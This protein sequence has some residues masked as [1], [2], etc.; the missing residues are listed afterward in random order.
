MKC[1]VFKKPD[2]RV[3]YSWPSPKYQGGHFVKDRS[4]PIVVEVDDKEKPIIKETK[5]LLKK[6]RKIVGYVKKKVIVDYKKKELTIDCCK[7]PPETDGLPYIDLDESD[8]PSEEGRDWHG[9]GPLHIEGELR[10]E[11]LKFDEKWEKFLMPG[12]VI[13]SKEE[14]NIERYLDALLEQKSPDPIE[15]IR[16]FRKLQKV[17]KMHYKRDYR[18]LCEIAMDGLDRAEIE[19]PTIRQK[20][21]DKIK[22]LKK[23][24]A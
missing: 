16:A 14:G 5:G 21:K 23:A 1:R 8:L 17:S 4:K 13:K 22:E 7:F 2:G 15:A 11:N 9:H 19:K 3:I 20:L 12:N 24:G 6:N 18:K 10:K